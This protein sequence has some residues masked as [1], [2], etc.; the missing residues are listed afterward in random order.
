LAE[1]IVGSEGFRPGDKSYIRGERGKTTAFQSMEMS[2]TW[3]RIQS[4][5]ENRI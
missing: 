4:P 5:A 3:F 2:M 1:C